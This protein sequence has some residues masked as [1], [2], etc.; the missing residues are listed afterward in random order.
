MLQFGMQQNMINLYYKK[1][2][3]TLNKLK[4]KDLFKLRNFKEKISKNYIRIYYNKQ[5]K[6]KRNLKIL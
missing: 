5:L 2:E 6:L 1:T 4:I 3:I